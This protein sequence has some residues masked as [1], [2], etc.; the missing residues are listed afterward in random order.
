MRVLISGILGAAA[1]SFVWFY[2]EHAT[3]SEMGWLAIGVGLVTGLCVNAAAG[4]ASRESFGRA[5]LA[6]ILTLTAVVG[7]RAVYA[8]VMQTMNTVETVGPVADVTQEAEAEGEAGGGEGEVTEVEEPDMS[9]RI[10]DGA[11]AGVK[12]EKPAMNSLSVLDMVYMGVSAL[13]AYVIGKGRTTS[14]VAPSEP[15]AVDDAGP[16]EAAPSV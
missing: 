7:G 5:A 11:G 9:L 10:P 3:K 14:T 6:V 16:S 8:K 12:L 2:L 13:V 1:S 15:E 4:A